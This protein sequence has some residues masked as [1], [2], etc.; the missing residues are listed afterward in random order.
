MKTIKNDRLELDYILTEMFNRVGKIYK[1]YKVKRKEW[2]LKGSWTEDE[3]ENFVKWLT[4][5]LYNNKDYRKRIM[6]FDS[7]SKKMCKD[8]AFSFVMD[9]GWKIKK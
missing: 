1:Q 3:E 9:Y 6:A 8:A 2:F 5:L 7:S 4:N